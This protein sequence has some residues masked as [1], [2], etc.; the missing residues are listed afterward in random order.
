MIFSAAYLQAQFRR[1]PVMHDRDC[2]LKIQYREFYGLCAKEINCCPSHKSKA[3]LQQRIRVKPALHT[4]K[5]MHVLSINKTCH[6]YPRKDYLDPHSER[7]HKVLQEYPPLKKRPQY[8]R[9]LLC[10]PCREHASEFLSRK[11]QGL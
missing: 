1:Q 9:P 2:L 10:I 7:L 4:T 5:C 6:G 8:E 3:I 11:K